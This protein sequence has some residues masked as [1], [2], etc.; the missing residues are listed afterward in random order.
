[1]SSSLRDGDGLSPFRRYQ[2]RVCGV[3]WRV[4]RSGEVAGAYEHDGFGRGARGA[5]Q[6]R[7]GVGELRLGEDGGGSWPR[8]TQD[9]RR[10]ELGADRVAHEGAQRRSQ[11]LGRY[12]TK[13]SRTRAGCGCSEKRRGRCPA[14]VQEQERGVQGA[15]VVTGPVG[16]SSKKT[17]VVYRSSPCGRVQRSRGQRR[18]KLVL[19]EGEGGA[20]CVQTTR[21]CMHSQQKEGKCRLPAC[22]QEKKMTEEALG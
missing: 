17:S 5:R 2:W 14:R 10:V 9:D 20:V 1:V 6:E 7:G 12:S 3:W 13:G 22:F 16:V 18:V 21:Y 8:I 11:A 4:G 19:G 15:V